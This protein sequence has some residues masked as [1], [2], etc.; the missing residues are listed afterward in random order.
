MVSS[1]VSKTLPSSPS[2]VPPRPASSALLLVAPPLLRSASIAL[3]LS[4]ARC[5]R[6]GR[7]KLTSA[8]LQ[9]PTKLRTL[10][11]P[12]TRIA[13][14]APIRV[15]AN[16]TR[17]CSAL[18]AVVLSSEG[19]SRPS[20]PSV[21]WAQGTTRRGALTTT[22]KVMAIRTASG[23]HPD[24]SSLSTSPAKPSGPVRGRYSI[25]TPSPMI[26][27]AIQTSRS[28]EEVA[29]PIFSGSLIP[30]RTL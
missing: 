22:T 11:N 12:G 27:Y 21:S 18:V 9:A 4:S 14:E 29:V 28:A 15:M 19:L 2:V 10:T 23:I 5:S 3:R 24:G 1:S 8:T 13:M 6:G 26:M 25:A 16:R 30:S 17:T 7:T 20:F